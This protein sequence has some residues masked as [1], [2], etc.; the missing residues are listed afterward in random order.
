MMMRVMPCCSSRKALSLMSLLLMSLLP[1]LRLHH[2][3]LMEKAVIAAHGMV[4]NA[5]G[6]L[7]M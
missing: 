6:T 3:K 5:M 2:E 7:V 4:L 1:I